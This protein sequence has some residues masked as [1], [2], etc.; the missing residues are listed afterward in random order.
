MPLANPVLSADELTLYY[1]NGAG[2]DILASTRPSKAASFS[3]DV[4]V[5]VINTGFSDAPAF[6][7]PD[8]YPGSPPAAVIRFRALT[9]CDAGN[10]M[11]IMNSKTPVARDPT[12][13]GRAVCWPAG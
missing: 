5:A 6:L 11:T 13:V 2:T 8:R 9:S 3:D 10:L 7:T 1:S 12:F 4:P